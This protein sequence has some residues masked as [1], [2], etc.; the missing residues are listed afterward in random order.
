VVGTL[1]AKEASSE[2]LR[3][4]WVVFG[5]ALALKMALGRDDWKIADVL[6]G[7][8]WI[9]AVSFVIGVLATLMGIGGATFTVPFLTLHGRALLQ[10][11]AT[12][13]GIGAIIAVPGLIGYMLSG[14]GAK[15]LP[16]F[17]IGYVSLGALLIAPLAVFAA[18][19]GVRMAHGIPKRKLELAFSVF[20]ACV[21][22]RFLTSLVG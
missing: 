22:V 6:P 2:A 16:A 13:T 5:S 18:P 9:E 17:S 12:A 14:L 3:W 15:G 11:V 1:I 20:L 4:V 8:P 7:R 10:S 19:Y 21:V